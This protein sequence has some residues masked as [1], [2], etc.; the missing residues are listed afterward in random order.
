MLSGCLE[1]FVDGE[2][3]LFVV[4]AGFSVVLPILKLYVLFRLTSP[5]I[6]DT[7]KYGRY[8]SLMHDYGRWSMLD[9]FVVAVLVVSV[10]LGAIAN[11]DM[12]YG[13]FIFTIAVLSTMFITSQVV[14]L[15]NELEKG[16][17]S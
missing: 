16:E 11:V 14:H 8:L 9:V 3:L 15:T 13:L 1:L 2:V 4:V 7:E 17:E 6:I 12:R 5:V 10:K